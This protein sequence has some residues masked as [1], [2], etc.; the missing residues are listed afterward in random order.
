MVAEAAEAAQV[1]TSSSNLVND[2]QYQVLPLQNPGLELTMLLGDPLHCV[3]PVTPPEWEKTLSVLSLPERE[4]T[5]CVQSPRREG[6]TPCVQPPPEGEK[7]PCVHSPP[8][9]EK[10]LVV[11]SQDIPKLVQFKSVFI[12]EKDLPVG[13]RLRQFLP[14][15]EKH[16]SHRLITGLI[17]DRYKLPFRE[18]PNL[19]KCLMDLYSRPAAERHS[20][21]HSYPR[22]SGIL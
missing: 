10:T 21:S 22:K 7:T 8:E 18:R 19:S 12:S 6:K 17:R 4:K 16:G 14:E 11:R 2:T 15:W 20:R 13:G 1:V 9:G 5:P 3:F